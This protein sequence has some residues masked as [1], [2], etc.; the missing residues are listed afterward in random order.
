MPTKYLTFK[1]GINGSNSTFDHRMAQE[2]FVRLV[3]FFDNCSSIGVTRIAS[4]YGLNTLASGL[5]TV[6]YAGGGFNYWNESNS[7]G[8]HAWALYRFGSASP[9]FYMLLHWGVAGVGSYGNS[10][11]G[12]G[13]STTTIP[14]DIQSAGNGGVGVQFACREDGSNPWGSAVYSNAGA[15]TKP[16][17]VWTPSTGSAGRLYVWPRTNSPGGDRYSPASG[18]SRAFMMPILNTTALSDGGTAIYASIITVVNESNVFFAIDY[19]SAGDMN[20]VAFCK[21]TPASGSTSNVPYFSFTEWNGTYPLTTNTSYGTVAQGSWFTRDGGIGLPISTVSG[22]VASMMMDHPTPTLWNQTLYKWNMDTIVTGTN[23]GVG[24]LSEYPI[25]LYATE[26]TTANMYSPGFIGYSYDFLRFG[27]YDTIPH[28]ATLSGSTRLHI[29]G[30]NNSSTTND[31]GARVT[32]PW[33]GSLPNPRNV[34]SRDG[35]EV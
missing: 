10:A 25:L 2:T 9:N 15:D 6:T 16:N 35:V 20:T 21:Y 33:T 18:F 23:P 32:I 8:S 5:P 1:V 11:Q 12:L 17:P 31:A 3:K 19:R 34:Y 26:T 14:G 24:L 22:T 29:G 30:V 28:Y 4:N 13:G 7:A 27:G